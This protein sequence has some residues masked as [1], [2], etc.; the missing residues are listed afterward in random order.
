MLITRIEIVGSCV[1]MRRPYL[2]N[3]QFA[4]KLNNFRNEQNFGS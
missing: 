2:V 1:L 3:R 4:P